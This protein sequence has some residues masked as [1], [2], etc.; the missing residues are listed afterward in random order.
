MNVTDSYRQRICRVI[1]P[2]SFFQAQQRSNHLLHLSFVCSPVAADG[3]LYS[4]WGVLAHLQLCLSEDQHS[5]ARSLTDH[6]RRIYMLAHKEFLYRC[7][8]RTVEGQKLGKLVREIE[9][10]LGLRKLCGCFNYTILNR[11]K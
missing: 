7:A 9:Q 1:R 5:Y 10:P 11:S 6:Q 3:L 8:F 2:W 4:H